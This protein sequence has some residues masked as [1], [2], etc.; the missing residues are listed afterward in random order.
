[1]PVR[2]CSNGK[3][4]IGSG[5]CMYGS[6]AA[7]DKAYRAYRAKK[8]EKGGKGNGKSRKG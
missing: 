2:K 4:A 6:K 8:G 3:W 1:M 7:A 5:P